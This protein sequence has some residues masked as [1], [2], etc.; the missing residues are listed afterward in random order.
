MESRLSVGCT[1]P[2]LGVAGGIESSVKGLFVGARVF[3]KR[4]R[5][6]AF[7]SAGNEWLEMEGSE[8]GGHVCLLFDL[9][10]RMF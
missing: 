5:L 10:H 9:G 1:A 4:S 3:A 2:V 6:A 7:F 8:V